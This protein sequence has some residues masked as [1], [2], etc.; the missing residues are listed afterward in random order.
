[1]LCVDLFY[2]NDFSEIW[3][4]LLVGE[5]G[6]CSDLNAR[7]FSNFTLVSVRFASR[8][9]FLSRRYCAT[10]LCSPLKCK[11]S[12]SCIWRR[13]SKRFF[14][15]KRVCWHVTTIPKIERKVLDETFFDD[16]FYPLE[17]VWFG[18]NFV[19]YWSLDHRVRSLWSLSPRDLSHRSEANVC[20]NSRASLLKQNA[21]WQ[22][23]V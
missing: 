19:F 15:R 21:H 20:T 23:A 10:R 16:R 22:S 14:S 4:E 1:M 5:W 13:A 8:F 6:S 2:S 12:F 7:F 11:S 9:S 18:N 3:S 17:C